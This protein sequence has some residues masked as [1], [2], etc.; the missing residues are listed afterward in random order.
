MNKLL[1]KT[2]I[3]SL[4]IVA[5]KLKNAPDHFG[6]ITNP[7]LAAPLVDVDLKLR[8]VVNSQAVIPELSERGD[9]VYVI[10]YK[11]TVFTDTIA[12]YITLNNQNFSKS[13]QL[14]ASEVVIYNTGVPRNFSATSNEVLDFSVSKSD[15]R[16]TKV[17]FKSGSVQLKVT[18]KFPYVS[19]FS[20]EFPDI[21]NP[22]TNKTLLFSFTVPANSNNLT[23]NVDLSGYVADLTSGGTTQN[24]LRYTVSYDV[25]KQAPTGPL[26]TAANNNIT[27]DGSILNLKYSYLEGYLGQISLPNVNSYV[28]VE[29][30]K[31]VVKGK[32]AFTEPV[33]KINFD[34][35]S[36]IKADVEVDPLKIVFANKSNTDSIITRNNSNT[37]L[38]TT[39]APALI[40]APNTIVTTNVTWNAKNSNITTAFEPS[41]FNVYYNADVVLNKQVTGTPDLKNFITDK[42]VIRVRAEVELPIIGT[43]YYLTIADTVDL[44]SGNGLTSID[45]DF[46][47][48]TFKL[49]VENG[50]PIDCKIQAYFL[51]SARVIKDS[52]IKDFNKALLPAAIVDLDGKILSKSRQYYQRSFTKPVYDKNIKET[53]YILVVGYLHSYNSTTNL[54]VKIFADNTLKVKLSGEVRAKIHASTKD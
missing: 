41:P 7:G 17:I 21:V 40:T 31:N 28:Q 36:G 33:I 1:L 6:V 35:S 42:S 5:C 30:F 26:I 9:K 22:T 52:L 19:N 3:L 45:F 50:F 29:L 10:T 48:A 53:R 37:F 25:L 51:D 43:L 14:P 46:D 34:N 16:L 23:F 38:D 13:Y 2:C 4:F 8:D 54:P 27:I 20:V 11:D 12:K 49:N 18:S 32:V 47:S 44:P 15:Q 24:K 39:I